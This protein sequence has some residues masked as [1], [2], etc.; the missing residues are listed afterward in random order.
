M[1]NELRIRKPFEQFRREESHI[2]LEF[3]TQDEGVRI[4]LK[5]NLD[6]NV[7]LPL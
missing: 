5:R 3:F 6:K 1:N 2:A 7:P 4:K